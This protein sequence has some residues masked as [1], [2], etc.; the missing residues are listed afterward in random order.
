MNTNELLLQLITALT[1][2][3][4]YALTSYVRLLAPKLPSFTI[5][6]VAMTLGVAVNYLTAQA[7][8]TALSPVL[9]ALYG[10]AAI[11]VNKIVEA[12]K[13]RP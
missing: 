8:G 5:P 10:S 1:P 7:G 6:L 11:L 9:A 12:L 13:S 4:A 3:I 2:V